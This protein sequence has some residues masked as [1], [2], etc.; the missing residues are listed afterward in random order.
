MVVIA[1]LVAA[2]PAAAATFTVTGT[3]DITGLCSGTSCSTIR[4]AL[5][6]AQFRAPA[7]TRS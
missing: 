7:R 3:T 1:L 2:S 4:A 6:A 5:A